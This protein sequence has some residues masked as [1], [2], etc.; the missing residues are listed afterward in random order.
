M[1]RVKTFG[2]Y[3]V[4]QQKRFAHIASQG[5]IHQSEVVVRVQHI[6][7]F[8]GL[9]VTDSGTAERHQLV[10]DTQRIAHTSVSFLCHHIQCLFAGVNAFLLSYILQMVNRVSHRNTAEVIHLAAAQD[11]RQ[12]FVL[13][14]GRQDKDSIR[15]WLLQCLQQRIESALRKHVHLVND[16]HAV[17]T[18]LWW[19]THL[20]NQRTDVFHRVVGRCVQLVDIKRTLFVERHARLALVACIVI[21]RRSQTV[22]GLGKDTRTSG[23]T[24]A[25]WTAK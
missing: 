9:L 5:S 24:H 2:Q 22:D 20:V 12:H 13:L 6:Q 23:L 1:S 11:R 3:L 4:Q 10:K 19:D 14:G 21:I 7:H 17:L 16:I 15:W 25:A 18:N 8:D